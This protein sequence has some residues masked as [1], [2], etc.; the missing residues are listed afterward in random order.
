[1]SK[2]TIVLLAVILVVFFTIADNCLAIQHQPLVTD[3]TGISLTKDTK[4]KLFRLVI[5]PPE[6][7]FQ[8]GFNELKMLIKTPNSSEITGASVSIKPWMPSMGHGVSEIPVVKEIGAGV[9]IASNVG[10]SM[11]GQWQLIVN[12]NQNGKSDEAIFEFTAVDMGNQ[13]MEGMQQHAGHDMEQHLTHRATSAMGLHH[14]HSAA[15][16]MFQYRFMRMDM[17]GLLD[18]TDSILPVDV[19]GTILNPGPYLMS[20]TAMTMDMHML[21]LMYGFT[22]KFTV[23]GMLNYLDNEMDMINRLG[24]RPTM[25]TR[26]F[27]DTVLTG[28]YQLNQNITASLG[29]SFPTGSIDEKVVMMG[30]TIQAPYP[31]QLGSGTYDIIPS[32]TYSDNLKKWYWGAEVS[33]TARVGENDNDYTLGDRLHIKAAS[34]Y[35]IHENFF[36]N[37]RL[38]FSDWDNID[39]MDPGIN[40][41]MAPTGD[42]DAQGGNRTDIFFGLTTLL[43]NS[44]S[45]KAEI[46]IP[47]QQNLDGPQMETKY[48]F[49][50]VYQFM[51]M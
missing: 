5:Y 39:G 15:G 47:I 41:G 23:M 51:P 3:H 21:M 48:I 34:L 28:T 35:N 17:D 19:T 36:V 14:I 1:M 33:Y 50:L 29:L 4:N 37:T 16:W 46:G 6:G 20:P 44:H 32:I 18:G 9:Y 13:S 25:E 43:G 38:V 27:G 49:S 7:G 10:F 26:G 40:P 30:N 22:E 8:V 2:I 11:P 24:V 31:M 12:T 45:L 42:P